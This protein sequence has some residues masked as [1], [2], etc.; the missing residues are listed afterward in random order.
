MVQ[1]DKKM[2]ILLSDKELFLYQKALNSEDKFEIL[3]WEKVAKSREKARNSNNRIS[4]IS[5]RRKEHMTKTEFKA[6]VTVVKVKKDT[7]TVI[8]VNGL[9]YVLDHNSKPK[10]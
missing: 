6:E 9:R 2:L 4:W 3:H 5:L 1:V 10:K 8:E 7:P